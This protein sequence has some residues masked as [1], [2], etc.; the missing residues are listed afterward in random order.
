MTTKLQD[1]KI[2]QIS[3]IKKIKKLR[4]PIKIKINTRYYEIENF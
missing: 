2:I 3:K 4:R 1:T